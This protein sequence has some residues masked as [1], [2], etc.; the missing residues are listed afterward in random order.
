MAGYNWGAGKSNNAV[1]AE[2]VEGKVTKSKITAAWLRRNEIDETATF[3]KFLITAD[4]ILPD[5]WHHTSKYFNETEYYSAETIAETLA[6]LEEEGRL[7]IWREMSKIPALRAQAGSQFAKS[8]CVGSEAGTCSATPNRPGKR[9]RHARPRH[10]Q[11]ARASRR[12]PG[13]ITERTRHAR[14]SRFRGHQYHDSS[15]GPGTLPGR[16]C[17]HARHNPNHHIPMGKRCPHPA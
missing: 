9:T 7:T 1:W 13:T 17:R 16:V 3:V 10:K 2:E 15:K 12:G 5:E 11:P 14:R 6:E 4:V 8:S